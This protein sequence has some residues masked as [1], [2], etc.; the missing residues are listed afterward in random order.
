ME[1]YG[2]SLSQSLS[3]AQSLATSFCGASRRHESIAI[4]E[5]LDRI[6]VSA[7]STARS[8]INA[9]STINTCPD[10]VVGL[11]LQHAA[12]NVEARFGLGF[13]WPFAPPCPTWELITLTHVCRHW[14]SLL[15][16]LPLLWTHIDIGNP[17]A[18]RDLVSTFLQRSGAA[19]L[20]VYIKKPSLYYSLPGESES[21]ETLLDALSPRIQELH[22]HRDALG[23]ERPFPALEILTLESAGR[24]PAIL[25]DGAA[26]Q[27][28]ALTMIYIVSLPTNHFPSLTR[29]YVG[30]FAW[31]SH[32]YSSVTLSQLAVFLR[33]C[34]ALEEL[35]VY[36]MDFEVSTADDA[37]PPVALGHLCRL[38]LGCTSAIVTGWFFDHI[39]A[40][41]AVA[42]RVFD[43]GPFHYHA[44]LAVTYPP[45]LRTPTLLHLRQCF[46][47]AVTIANSSS[48]VRF[49]YIPP[50]PNC[51]WGIFPWSSWP[52]STVEELHIDHSS[53]E[54][55]AGFH[56]LLDVL[57]SLSLLVYRG[58]LKPLI[59]LLGLLSAS[60]GPPGPL[61][62][63]L[64][65]LHISLK[66]DLSALHVLDDFAATRA[67]SGFPLSEVIIEYS[68]RGA[69]NNDLLPGL[70]LIKS[71]QCVR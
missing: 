49:E 40:S 45:Q 39:E 6:L 9:L 15:L 5:S 37:L 56:L 28:R 46:E 24:L 43:L 44:A 64:K 19:P 23:L 13:R 32:L 48:A 62:P 69:L 35:A 51:G 36:R 47:P 14:R 25:F 22:V 31:L 50:S 67:R 30:N 8:A 21:I 55:E 41:P 53:G 12:V 18:Y 1:Y 59:H 58:K 33:G 42:I 27:L 61:C 17:L 54:P 52:V 71:V 60:H 20:K 38:S 10:D 7:L 3:E 4:L 57:P 26:P 29:L 68:S 70:S 65:T 11:I 16:N 66:A 34:N 63:A 2:H